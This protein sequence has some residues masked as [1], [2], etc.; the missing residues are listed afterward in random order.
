[1]K[2]TDKAFLSEFRDH[3][4]VLASAF[5]CLLFAFSAP[6]FALPFLYP[7]IIEEF[8]W[9]REQ[10]TLIATAKYAAGAIAA[11]IVGRFVDLIGVR[12]GLIALSALGGLAM[13]SFLWVPQLTAYYLVGVLLG[14]S[15]TGTIVAVKV[16]IARRFHRSQGTAMSVA[17][18]ATALGA[19]VTPYIVVQLIDAYGWRSA[20]ALLS[21][22][23]W[24]VALPV[25]FFCIRDAQLQ[26]ASP[27]PASGDRRARALK[28]FAVFARQRRFWLIALALFSAALVDQAFIQHQVLYLELDL[29]LSPGY[30][31]AGIGSIGLVGVLARVFVGAV[32]DRWSARGVSAM[33]LSLAAAALIALAALNPLLFGMFVVL[34]AVGHAAVLLDSAVL[35]KHVFGFSNLGFLL[36]IYTGIVAI[37]F[38]VGP[39]L[40]GR[41]YEVTGSYVL[42]FG[43]CAVL[44]VFAAAILLPVRP[45]HWLRIRKTDSPAAEA[46]PAAAA[47]GAS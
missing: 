28:V 29:G 5:T 23:T 6:A 37:G 26:D 32:F 2:L 19:T 30:V 45:A 47:K 20:A 33:Y 10:V 34:R 46:R 38:A 9:N 31:A 24:V 8:S 21:L 39:W 14:V 36:G 12:P 40:V 22:G 44:A 11:V 27:P 4:V 35:S 7:S 16:L 41:L 25:L 17:L 42:P 15:G 43:L 1:M 3:W 18:L 13:V